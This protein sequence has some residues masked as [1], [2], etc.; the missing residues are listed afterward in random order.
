MATWKLKRTAQCAKCPW[1][2]AVDPHDIPNGYCETKHR[3]LAGTI[4]VPGD[5][6]RLGEPLRVM[7]CHET[8]QAHCVGWLHNQVGVGNN[9]ALRLKMASCE[10]GHKLRLRGDQHP[11]FAA[12]LPAAKEKD[13]A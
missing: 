13:P 9:I 2:T 1:R 3:D 12:T 10:N 7:A 8:E 4:A 5:I 6:S 11:N